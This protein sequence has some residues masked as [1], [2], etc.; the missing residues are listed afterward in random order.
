MKQNRIEPSRRRDRESNGVG[1]T[2]GLLP[3]EKVPSPY[4]AIPAD[5]DV[6]T[7]VEIRHEDVD[8][9]MKSWRA[10]VMAPVCRRE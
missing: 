2:M 8:R 5:A 10:L 6:N 9:R 1:H 3:H 7:E 4:Q